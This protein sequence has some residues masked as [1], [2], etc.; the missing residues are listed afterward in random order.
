MSFLSSANLFNKTTLPVSHENIVQTIQTF[1]DNIFLSRDG[2]TSGH[3]WDRGSDYHLDVPAKQ[4]PA[5]TMTKQLVETYNT[6]TN[7]DGQSDYWSCRISEHKSIDEDLY[8]EK[9][10]GNLNGS[11]FKKET[12]EWELPEKLSYRCTN[13]KNYFHA[14][15]SVTVLHDNVFLESA[16]AEN[17]SSPSGGW[18]EIEA[19]YKFSPVLKKRVFNEWVYVV[20]PFKVSGDSST[21]VSYVLSIRSDHNQDGHKSEHV[22]AYYVSIEKLQY[23]YTTK[24]FTW[25][26]CTASD[27]KGIVPQFVQNIM[28]NKAVVHDV[29]LFFSYIIK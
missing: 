1:T 29:P 7:F 26:M 6:Y 22:P 9:I 23:N 14:I 25:L 11:V 4:G 10:V 19:L 8:R 20:K 3:K 5:A 15:E 27:C 16:S 28:I 13:E 24:Q 2:A 18:V 12:G 17:V 21:E